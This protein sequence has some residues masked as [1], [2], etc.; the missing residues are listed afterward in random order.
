[1]ILASENFVPDNER[2][3]VRQEEDLM[4]DSHN[5][6]TKVAGILEQI[7]RNYIRILNLKV[8]E[9]NTHQLS[10]FKFLSN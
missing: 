2:D 5:H 1:M 6:G 10:D 8:T 3:L 7:A 4:Q 9:H